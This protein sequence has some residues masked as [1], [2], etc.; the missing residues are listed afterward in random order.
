VSLQTDE[1]GRAR[2]NASAALRVGTSPD[3]RHLLAPVA[4]AD[5][6]DALHTVR[7]LRVRINPIITLEKQLLNMMNMIE[8]LV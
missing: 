5:Y 6:T 8:N 7:G 1:N 3:E 2:R 4:A